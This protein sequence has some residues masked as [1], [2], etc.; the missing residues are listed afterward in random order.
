MDK[1]RLA[2]TCTRQLAPMLGYQCLRTPQTNQR[3][4]AGKGELGSSRRSAPLRNLFEEVRQ[5][6]L[7]RTR[8]LAHWK[9]HPDREKDRKQIVAAQ[10]HQILAWKTFN[11]PPPVAA[12]HHSAPYEALATPYG[13]PPGSSG[14]AACARS[15]L[16]VPLPVERDRFGMKTSIPRR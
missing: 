14:A 3:K 9:V 12:R 5:L 13:S 7:L 6:L 1:P 10:I 16:A 8:A 2:R 15:A 11:A 4:R